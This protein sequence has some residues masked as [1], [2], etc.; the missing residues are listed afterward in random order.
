VS[1]AD[2]VRQQVAGSGYERPGFAERY[3]AHRPRPPEVLHA[4]LPA[5]AGIERPRLVVDLGSGTGLSTRFWAEHADEV[6]GVEPQRRMREW[7]EAVTEAPNVS[8]L[9]RSA[10]D[11]G[12]TSGSADIVTAA[13]S[14]QW[15]EPGP[16]FAEIGRI[17][18]SGGVFCAYEYV[19]LQTPLWE[20][21]AAWGDVI[22]TKRRL[23]V[24]RGLE[25]RAFP[26][27]LERLRESGVFETVR[28]VPLQSVEEGDGD[29]LVEL[30]LSEG[31]L[32]TLLETGVS[33]QEVGLDRLREVARS[34]PSVPWWIGYRALIGRKA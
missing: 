26:V 30:A 4:L 2:E 5:L 32:V 28:E 1:R 12:I 22:A 23:R 29:R 14:L 15:M 9:D 18:R 13:Q 16:V 27:S 6:I 24:E 8:Y 11:T 3:D 25:N 17:L 33:E 10:D 7:A 31:S 20:P 21:E 19:H 34:M